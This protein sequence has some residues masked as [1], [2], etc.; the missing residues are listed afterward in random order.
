MFGNQLLTDAAA[1]CLQQFRA[2]DIYIHRHNCKKG[3]SH[4]LRYW[5]T[6]F[7]TASSGLAACAHRLCV[8]VRLYPQ[9]QKLGV[10]VLQ[11]LDGTADRLPWR[12]QAAPESSWRLPAARSGAGRHLA[13]V[14]RNSGATSTSSFVSA[15]PASRSMTELC[16][17]P[18]SSRIFPACRR[19]SQPRVPW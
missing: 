9:M 19:G 10:Y 18:I 16:P 12:R 2:F 1:H 14:L 7:I 6:A 17:G 5:A 13:L 15:I 11:A 3:C 4:R 8:A